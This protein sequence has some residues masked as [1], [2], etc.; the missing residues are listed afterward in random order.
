MARGG[1][2]GHNT[3]V[4][5]SASAYKPLDGHGGHCHG[6]GCQGVEN[7]ASVEVAAHTASSDVAADEAVGGEGGCRC[8]RGHLT[9]AEVVASKVTMQDGHGECCI[10]YETAVWLRCHR[11]ER[12]HGV[13][14]QAVAGKLLQR[15]HMA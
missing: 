6:R 4:E 15:S 13:C 2:Q 14:L 7:V 8:G 5:I 9:I 11:C 1:G 10:E 3:T 12:H